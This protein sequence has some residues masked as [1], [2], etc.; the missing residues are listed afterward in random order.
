MNLQETLMWLGLQCLGFV[1][2]GAVVYVLTRILRFQTQPWAFALAPSE[3][4]PQQ[5]T[6]A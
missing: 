6:Q 2:M 1:V 5:L 3:A 4:A